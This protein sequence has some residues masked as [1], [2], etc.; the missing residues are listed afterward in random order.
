MRFELRGDVDERLLDQW[1]SLCE[2]VGD[3]FSA[4]PSYGLNWF[5]RL[6]KGDLAIAAVYDGDALMALLPMHVRNWL[7]VKVHRL[8]GHGLGT[9]G[10]VL[11]RNEQALAELVEGL[12]TSVNRLQLSHLRADEPFRKALRTHGGWDIEFDVDDFCPTVS[13]PP[14]SSAS[15]LRSKSSIKRALRIRRTLERDGLPLEFEVVDNTKTF[16]SRWH[17]IV[18]T[19]SEAQNSEFD[20]R[21]NLCAEPYA[22]FTHAFLREEAERGNLLVWGTRFDGHWAAHF[23]TIRTNNVIQAWITRYAPEVG[24]HRP[25]HQMLQEICDTHD[26]YGVFELDLLIGRNRYKS[27]WQTGGY[28]VGTLNASPRSKKVH[29]RWAAMVDHAASTTKEVAST[30]GDALGRVGVRSGE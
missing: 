11:F 3:T 12:H 1:W 13:L 5:R 18:H 29:R 20:S 10:A 22:T 2:E 9:I 21:L 28:E 24:R 15:T 4:R 8:L 19:A 26:Q 7:G 17:D 25:G 30:V 23:V 27:D 6:G 16:D 14:G